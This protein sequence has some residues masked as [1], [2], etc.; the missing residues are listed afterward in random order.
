[1]NSR[2]KNRSKLFK[3]EGTTTQGRSCTVQTSKTPTT[4]PTLRIL[5]CNNASRFF[6]F[7]YLFLFSTHCLSALKW[8]SETENWNFLR[9]FHTPHFPHSAFST[10]RTPRFPPNQKRCMLKLANYI[11]FVTGGLPHVFSRFQ[12]S[13]ERIE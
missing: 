2:I 10:L 11:E 5:K 4:I 9:I 13:L 1:M 12:E 8:E 6:V 3:N 7:V